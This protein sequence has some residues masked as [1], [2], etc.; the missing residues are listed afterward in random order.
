MFWCSQWYSDCP[1]RKV[2]AVLNAAG[3][4]SPSSRQNFF[5][6]NYLQ[7]RLEESQKKPLAHHAEAHNVALCM[8]VNLPGCPVVPQP[9]KGLAGSD[10]QVLFPDSLKKRN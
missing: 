8:F 5:R 9:Q 6:A 7:H 4:A 2:Q 10:L 3:S 1:R